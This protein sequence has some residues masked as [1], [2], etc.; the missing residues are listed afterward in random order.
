M[1]GMK[2]W[3]VGRQAAKRRMLASPEMEHRKRVSRVT[4]RNKL[5][6]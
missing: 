4:S 5:P 2:G 1:C 6:Q 3:P